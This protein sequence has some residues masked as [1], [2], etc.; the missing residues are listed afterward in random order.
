VSAGSRKTKEHGTH[1][2][3]KGTKDKKK[4]LAQ[5]NATRGQKRVKYLLNPDKVQKMTNAGKSINSLIVGNHGPQTHTLT[6]EAVLRT[7]PS[8]GAMPSA[9]NS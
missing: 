1:Y 2:Q 7:V 6:L 9:M 8:P 4:C 3:R 5:K